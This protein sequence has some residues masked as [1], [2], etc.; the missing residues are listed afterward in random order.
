MRSER[1]DSQLHSQT[2]ERPWNQ[3]ADVVRIIW[4][5]NKIDEINITVNFA[6]MQQWYNNRRV[7][8]TPN[9][10]RQRKGGAIHIGVRRLPKNA[11]DIVSRGDEYIKT[12]LR[13]ILR[14]HI[15][16]MNIMRHCR[17]RMLYQEF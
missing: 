14:E 1:Y 8:Y 10:I 3:L 4:R 17:A 11:Q 7:L 13:L 5:R 6:K 15:A 16:N 9:V 2:L 12:M